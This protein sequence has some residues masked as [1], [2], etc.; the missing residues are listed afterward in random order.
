[1][2]T[3]A[4]HHRIV[5]KIGAKR[6][7][8]VYD[9]INT[10]QEFSKVEFIYGEDGSLSIDKT[11]SKLRGTAAKNLYKLFKR[12]IETDVA[13]NL[14]IS[15]EKSIFNFTSNKAKNMITQ[16]F[17]VVITIYNDRY[18]LIYNALNYKKSNEE[19][20]ELDDQI[21]W[22]MERILKEGQSFIDN[23]NF[24]KYPYELN[25]TRWETIINEMRDRDDVDR[26]ILKNLHS[27]IK[28]VCCGADKCITEK[29]QIRSLDEGSSSVT[30]CMVCG[31]RW[32]K[33]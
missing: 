19:S 20:K 25:K 26:E 8:K 31:H 29:V 30:T 24:I 23:I 17:T 28:C 32:V 16:K 3:K 18:R 11:L 21:S 22:L 4:I 15:L 1:M 10:E 5:K 33:H 7:V 12:H 6:N 2:P 14:A 9:G 27:V 13:K